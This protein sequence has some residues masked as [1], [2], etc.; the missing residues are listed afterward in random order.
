[1]C[2]ACRELSISSRR[3]VWCAILHNQSLSWFKEKEA[4]LSAEVHIQETND[5]ALCVLRETQL[6]LANKEKKGNA[7]GKRDGE[8]ARPPFQPRKNENSE[9]QKGRKG[10]REGERALRRS[11]SGRKENGKSQRGQGNDTSKPTAR[12]YLC[13]TMPRVSMP[14]PMNVAT[15]VHDRLE[16]RG[17]P[18]TPCPEVHPLPSC[19]A[20]K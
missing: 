12:T 17:R 5:K 7:K 18:Q 1:M 13:T 9:T 16:K 4:R 3:E 8:R 20:Q 10:K 2:A 6:L 15:A 19:T 11:R 14:V